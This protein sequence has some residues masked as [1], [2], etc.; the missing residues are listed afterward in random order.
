MSK[1]TLTDV[2]S[3][4]NISVINDNFNVIE[5]NINNDV[6]HIKGGQNTLYQDL[7]MNSND[8]LNANVINTQALILNGSPIFPTTQVSILPPNSV[9]TTQLVDG[10]VTD[11]K[12]SSVSGS[13][14]NFLQAGTGATSRN[15]QTKIQED[16]GV[17]IKDFGADTS[18][19]DNYGLIQA[20]ITATPAGRQLRIP[21]GAFISSNKPVNVYGVDITGPGS[22]IVTDSY[23]GGEQFNTY[24]NH[25]PIMW[26]KEYFWPVYNVI[27][28]TNSP[29]RCYTYGDSTVEGGF[30]FIDGPYFL[31]SL[32][33]DMV[34]AKGIRNAFNVTNRGVGGSNLSTWNPGPDIGIN[35]A[36]P[37]H[38]VILKSGINDGSF[39]VGTRLETF[40][41]NLR[42]GLQT[43]RNIQGGD[44]ATTAILLVGPNPTIDKDFHSRN[45]YWY[46][47]IRP[48]YEAAA[49]DFKCAFFDTYAYLQDVEWALGT[50][51][52][53]DTAPGG[54]PVCL[55]P[56]NVGNSWIWGAIIDFIFGESE[57]YRWRTNAFHNR[58]TFYGFPTAKMPPTWYP[59]NYNPGITVETTNTADGFPTNGILWTHKSSEAP[60]RQILMPLDE[61]GYVASRTSSTNSGFYGEWK[62]I[63][64]I[65]SLQN[66][67]TVFGAPYGVAKAMATS[68][69]TI[70]LSGLIRPGTTTAGT[71]LFTLPADMRPISQHIVTAA[72][73]GGT[74]QL[75]IMANG[76]VV[77]R[78]GTPTSFVSLS[79][80]SFLYNS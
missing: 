24:R 70:H 42:N 27:Q 48:I 64:K 74:L 29:I 30:N 55:H 16:V 39:P 46:E 35:S 36:N 25:K 54:N 78:N 76:S 5:D 50:W 56:R 57:S 12:I 65:M 10:S 73:E 9:G 1:I 49:R 14:V 38:L 80:I 47:Q 67:W 37:A 75:E 21:S 4:Y 41:N 79:N 58:S 62:G 13:K 26:G 18:L 63:P 59:T 6:F 60:L 77:L 20:A 11:A 3:G 31:Q 72:Y 7:D 40:K 34:S 44:V 52:N 33:P 19:S 8:I 32:L 43:I 71:L 53:N 51:I 66:G 22:L 15:Q 23:G 28:A 2:A 45:A 61:S 68:E 17:S 69:G